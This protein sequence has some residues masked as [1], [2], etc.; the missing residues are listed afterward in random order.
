LRRI[1]GVVKG[2]GRTI[3]SLRIGGRADRIALSNLA[4][5]SKSFERIEKKRGSTFD[6][7]HR[8]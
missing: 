4:R 8:G 3:Y 6:C 2:S 7:P 1:P 5:A